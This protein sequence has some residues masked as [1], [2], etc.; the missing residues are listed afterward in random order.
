[1]SYFATVAFDIHNGTFEDYDR[2]YEEFLKI[3]LS[4]VLIASDDSKVK[5]PD[6]TTAGTFN[7][8]SSAS[9]STYLADATQAAFVRNKLSG[10]I[11][12]AVGDNWAWS[13][14]NP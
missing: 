11:F 10:K 1:M 9:V 5:L 3:G 7:G 12:V 2:I 8:Q 14:R 13:S 4:R 6:S